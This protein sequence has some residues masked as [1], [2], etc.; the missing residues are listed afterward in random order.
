MENKRQIKE[1][2]PDYGDHMTMGEFILNV[3]CGGFTDDDG[4]AVYAS[5]T[6]VIGGRLYPSDILTDSYNR[7]A[8]HVVWFNK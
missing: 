2:L 4:Y 3:Q 6:H 8:T 1:A 7:H 5:E